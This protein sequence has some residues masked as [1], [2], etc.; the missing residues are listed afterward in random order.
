MYF[1]GGTIDNWGGYVGV[2]AGD[3]RKI[4]PVKFCYKDK[5]ALKK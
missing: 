4:S 2:K 3:I 5:T 1:P